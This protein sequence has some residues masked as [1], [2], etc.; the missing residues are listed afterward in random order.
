MLVLLLE[1]NGDLINV[2]NISKVTTEPYFV[3]N[4]RLSMILRGWLHVC[5]YFGLPKWSEVKSLLSIYEPHMLYTHVQ[6]SETSLRSDFTSIKKTEVKTHSGV[7]VFDWKNWF[8]SFFLH[9]YAL[10]HFLRGFCAFET[11]KYQLLFLSEVNVKW[12]RSEK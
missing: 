10:I 1:P 12:R 7:K 3:L 6:W 9:R 11:Q 2:C 8:S 4:L 5:F